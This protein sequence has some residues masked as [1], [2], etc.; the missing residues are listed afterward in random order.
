MNANND[1]FC[2]QDQTHVLTKLR[3]M[4]L[5]AGVE[6]PMGKYKATVEH[7]DTLIKNK[8]KDK[9]QLTRSD[10][11]LDDK[12]NFNSARK[13]STKVV[14]VVQKLKIVMLHKYT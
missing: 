13:I 8:S 6:L 12:M 4:L 14:Q 1:F 10:I 2:F 9:H 5:K 7:L 11:N 3:T